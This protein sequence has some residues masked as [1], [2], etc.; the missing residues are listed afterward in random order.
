L[1]AY[2]H[3]EMKNQVCMILVVS[4]IGVILAEVQ[5]MTADVGEGQKEY[6]VQPLYAMMA[7]MIVVASSFQIKKMFNIND[8]ENNEETMDK[9]MESI[10]EAAERSQENDIVN[11]NEKV[12]YNQVSDINNSDNEDDEE[13]K[14]AMEESKRVTKM[15]IEEEIRL[16]I[17]ESERE[18]RNRASLELQDLEQMK[19]VINFSREEMVPLNNTPDAQELS[20]VQ[21][22]A[23]YSLEVY[24]SDSSSPRRRRQP[25]PE[26][27]N[28]EIKTVSS[29]SS[30]V[31]SPRPDQVQSPSYH[32]ADE[33]QLSSLTDEQQME[34][35]LRQSQEDPTSM[36]EEEQIN[37][38]KKLSI[39]SLGQGII[40]P[41]KSSFS[42]RN[43]SAG[44]NKLGARPRVLQELPVTSNTSTNNQLGARPRQQTQPVAVMNVIDSLLQKSTN[45]HQYSSNSRK[46]QAYCTGCVKYLL[47]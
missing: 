41:P 5:M 42:S 26:S 11:N 34:L 38:A 6:S 40:S 17:E 28:N 47:Y 35:A 21:R 23:S 29:Y 20:P 45:K 12:T 30:V 7:V 2:L 16:A 39:G 24:S 44:H 43:S 25:R 37:Y 32:L 9:R 19:E 27:V 10:I 1:F 3:L 36:T 15:S 31:S 8:V 33:E 13:F 18:A 46:S 14:R 22:S 4:L